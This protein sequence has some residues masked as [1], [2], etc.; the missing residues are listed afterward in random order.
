MGSFRGVDLD[1]LTEAVPAFAT[2][3]LMVFIYSIANGL[4]AGL[5]LHPL[6]KAAAGR[7]RE[8]TPGSL[9]LGALCAAYYVFGLPH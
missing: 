5:V 3:A 7:F 8:I 4:T 2:L 9:V 6:M 1:D